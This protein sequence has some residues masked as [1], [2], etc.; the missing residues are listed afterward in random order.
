MRT[1]FRICVLFTLLLSVGS[2]G[3]EETEPRIGIEE[4]LGERIPLEELTF[5]D[6]EGAPL[7]LGT[8]FD[9]PVVL[10]LVYY[11]CPSICTPLLQEVAHVADLTDLEPG[12]D[13]RI[14]TISFDPNDSAELAKIKKANMLATLEH[15]QVPEDGWRFLTG[16]EDQIRRITEAVGFHYTR[17]ANEI[18]FVHAATVI[19]L[20]PEGKIVRYL[21]G[22]RFNPADLKMAVVDASE[23][24]AR[25][26]MQRIQR[27]C[28]SYDPEGRAYVLKI[29]RIILGVTLIFA[30][31]F[32]AFLFSKNFARRTSKAQ[33][34]GSA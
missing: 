10:T 27:L 17:D 23:G 29:N 31:A 28:Y 16:E 4:H 2:A 26:F 8:L 21:N 30:G 24:R 11:R 3:A 7:T 1:A 13:Y 32:G 19:F 33:T 22:T 5:T 34:T 9:R 6:E 15:K 25:S 18:D 20:S 14:V 12:E